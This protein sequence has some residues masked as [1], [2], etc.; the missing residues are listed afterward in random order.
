MQPGQKILVCDIGGGASRNQPRAKTRKAVRALLQRSQCDWADGITPG[1]MVLI[2]V[3]IGIID[4]Q[5]IPNL[6]LF[7][8]LGSGWVATDEVRDSIVRRQLTGFDFRS[9]GSKHPIWLDG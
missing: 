6:D 2:K 7:V 5:R 4:P 9:V 1:E 3:K 8:A